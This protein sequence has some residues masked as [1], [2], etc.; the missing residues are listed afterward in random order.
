MC[1]IMV[2][3]WNLEGGDVVKGLRDLGDEGGALLDGE[4]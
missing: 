3:R 1:M 2:E 4:C